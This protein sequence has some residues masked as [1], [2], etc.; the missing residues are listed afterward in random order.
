[1]TNPQQPSLTRSHLVGYAA[2]CLIWGSTWMA[3]RVTVADIP[4]LQAAALRFL[5]AALALIVLA[6]LQGKRRPRDRRQWNALL[7]LSLT[8]MALPYGLLF[9]AEQYV[10]SGMTAILY[11]SM[12]LIVALMMPLMKHK[13]VP[14]RAVFSMVMAFGGL[15]VLIYQG[16][17]TNGRA[18]LGCAAILLAVL[19]SAWSSVYAKSRIQEVDAVVSTGIQ[20]LFAAAALGWS[21][22]ALEAHRH[23]VWT[24]S[25]ILAMMFLIVFGSCAAFVIYY[26]LL[27]RMQPYQLS[28]ISLIV[29]VVA[30]LEGAWLGGEAVPFIM[31]VAIAVVLGSVST[32]LLARD[33]PHD[34][35]GKVLMIKGEAE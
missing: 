18:L 6:A 1:M 16:M 12:P 19:L 22:W 27:K 10:T 4:P 31:I 13:P 32:V 9:W 14:R 15:L 8:M 25:A 29:P 26:W 21:T 24:R 30:V 23:A 28:T 2:L 17:S 11:S 7:I 5:A 3:I 33:E 20:F 35:T 34:E